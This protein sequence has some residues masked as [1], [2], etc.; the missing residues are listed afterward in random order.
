[1]MIGTLQEDISGRVHLIASKQLDKTNNLT[2][3]R[4]IQDSPTKF[5]L[6]D[7]VPTEKLLIFLS[8]EAPYML[9]VGL[10]LKIFY[11]YLIHVPCLAHGLNEWRKKLGINTL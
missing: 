3:T 8:D 4:F 5:F 6:P 7:V 1:M 11:H 2:V 9:K 10:N